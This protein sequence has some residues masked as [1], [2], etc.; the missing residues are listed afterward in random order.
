MDLTFSFFFLLHLLYKGFGVYATF[1]YVGYLPDHLQH[2]EVGY[3]DSDN[4][5]EINADN[6]VYW[7]I[8]NNSMCAGTSFLHETERGSCRGDSGGPLLDKESGKL[9]G[10]LSGSVKVDGKCGKA[11]A[12]YGRI[13]E[14]VSNVLLCV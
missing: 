7:T 14:V 2:V 12:V 13:S 11:P 10:V 1:G 5:T 9:V 8:R 6:G 4:C 3:V